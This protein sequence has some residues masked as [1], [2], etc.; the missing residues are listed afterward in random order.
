MNEFPTKEIK[1]FEL[2]LK[3]ICKLEAWNW[4]KLEK[5]LVILLERNSLTGWSQ[6]FN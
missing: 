3:Y 2:F 5:K 4:T 1:E 6:Q